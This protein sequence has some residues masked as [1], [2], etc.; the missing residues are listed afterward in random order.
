MALE[1]K[2][3]EAAKALSL[4]ANISWENFPW[5]RSI[6]TFGKAL[7]A[8]H[9]KDMTAATKALEELRVNHKAAADK[10]PYEASQVMIQI[11]AIEGWIALL[12]G[13]KAEA[14]QSMTAS[15][16]MEDTLEKHP[17]TPG[18]VVPARELLGDLY[19]E[20]K[21]YP[22]ALEAYELDLKRHPER[23]NGL[24]GA[25]HAA[26]MSGQKRKLRCMKTN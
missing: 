11:K 15:A 18:E 21:D 25:A 9:L 8:I 26:K 12:E 4:K 13:N 2:D 3:W 5:E 24:I 16:D 7:G 10:N 14:I 22:N 17:V 23:L 20:M 19:M 1:R 6:I